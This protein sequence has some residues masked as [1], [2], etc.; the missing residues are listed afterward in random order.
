M[1]VIPLNK[2]AVQF[3]K[4]KRTNHRFQKIKMCKKCNRYSVLID[5]NCPICGS[6][7]IGIESLVK[8]IF[9][10]RLFT[11]SIWILILV[12]IGIVAAPTITTL[13]YS[14]ISGLIFCLAYVILTTF[15]MKSEYN[16][17]L[18]KM[19]RSDWTRIKEGIQFDSNLAK[20][21]VQENQL[22]TAY[23][24][25][26]E[27]GEFIENDEVKIRQVK[28]LNDIILRS[29][30]DLELERLVPS[31]YNSDFVLYTLDVLKF[32]RSLLTK[33]SIGY[34]IK[35]REEIIRDYGMEALI[36]VASSALRMKLYILEF[37][38]F[39]EEFLDYFPKERV[40]RLCSI[41]DSN[42][43]I[44]WGSLKDKTKR[45]VA[46]KYHYDPDFKQFVS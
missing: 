43:D 15:F 37:S 39:I 28:I 42:P 5:D 14:L 29:D 11:E 7:F 27:V 21:D 30:M 16:L 8:S 45:L 20:D 12:S 17:Q 41:L 33:K 24:K 1:K 46:M 32:N 34:F 18:K 38:E 44:K 10:N 3:S 26:R 9:K 2:L 36:F 6:D 23:E 25:L 13:Y 40:L 31:S 4:K 35:Y 22:A 19:L